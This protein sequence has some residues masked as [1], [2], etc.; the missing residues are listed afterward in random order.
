MTKAFNTS[1]NGNVAVIFALALVPIM[2]MLGAAVDYSAAST[3][4][5]NLQN[6][7]DV[8]VLAAAKEPDTTKRN[9][10]G[11]AF[12][13]SNLR[14]SAVV[15]SFVTNA[16]GTV[17]GTASWNFP[18]SFSGFVGMSSIAL[19][20]KVT[21][22]GIA[23]PPSALLQGDLRAGMVLEKIDLIVQNAGTTTETTLASYV[24]QMTSKNTSGGTLVASYNDG[25]GAMVAGPLD[26]TITLQ[27]NYQ[28]L[29][30]KMTVYEDGCGPGYVVAHDSTDSNF[31]CAVAGSAYVSNGYTKY[32]KSKTGPVIYTTNPKDPASAASSHNLFVQDMT[33]KVTPNG[34]TIKTITVN[35][36]GVAKTVTMVMMPNNT[37][38]SIFDILPCPSPPTASSSS[39][40]TRWNGS[41]DPPGGWSIQDFTFSVKSQTCA[42]NVNYDGSGAVTANGVAS[43]ANRKIYLR[44]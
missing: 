11:Q 14:Q 32:E 19:G 4:K 18:T 16:D 9:A 39:G 3:A 17:T 40:R 12:M 23:Q 38:P 20:A 34:K 13:A 22:D 8:A 41:G 29:Y 7:V 36:G 21:V 1:E 37:K 6:A 5:L 28:N 43:S 42:E 24:Y 33:G 25:T 2:A 15:S 27:K 35:V 10:L 30:L 26:K 44:D 31:K